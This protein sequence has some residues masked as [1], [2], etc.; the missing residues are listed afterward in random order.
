[1]RITCDHCGATFDTENNI[2]C[3]A[4]GATYS[5]D[6]ELNAV[7][8]YEQKKREYEL[9]QQ[10]EKIESQKIRNRYLNMQAEDQAKKYQSAERIRKFNEKTN[11]GCGTVLIVAGILFFLCIAI[12]IKMGIDENIAERKSR[13][14]T[15]TEEITT[16]VEIQIAEG[17][18][19]DDIDTGQWVFKIDKI[20]K[21]SAWP[22]N[23]SAGHSCVLIHALFTNN[24][25]Y[26]TANPN[27]IYTNI[28][29]NGIAQK[30]FYLP[31]EYK[32]FPNYVT[33]GLTVEGWYKYEIPDDADDMEFRFGEYAVC[34][35]SWDDVIE[36][37]DG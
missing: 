27:D 7:Q 5:D 31:S 6:E 1:M 36:Q 10:K 28:I 26:H 2:V 20:T 19:G 35:F 33:K 8:R 32:S 30:E 14:E 16:E 29:A 11:K 24:R 22:W 17:N 15:I 25:L 18:V 12:G 37:S 3:P 21:T 13:T 34:H 23:N 4:C 9:E